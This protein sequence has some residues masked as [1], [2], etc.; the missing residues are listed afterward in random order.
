M[1]SDYDG[2]QRTSFALHGISGLLQ[3]VSKHFAAMTPCQRKLCNNDTMPKLGMTLFT[4]YIIEIPAK[5]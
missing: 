4:I 1:T 2:M 5:L 3:F